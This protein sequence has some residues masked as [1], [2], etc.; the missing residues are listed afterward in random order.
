MLSLG[1]Q[2]PNR[3]ASC[4]VVGARR[5]SCPALEL[6][7]GVFAGSENLLVVSPFEWKTTTTP[8]LLGGDA[9]T[10]VT[11][12]YGSYRKHQGCCCKYKLV[13]DIGY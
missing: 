8:G 3:L 2:I 1:F 4:V 12:W 6:L 13:L 9:S 5:S 7:I 11:S 10:C